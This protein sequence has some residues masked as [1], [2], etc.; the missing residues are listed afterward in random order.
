[1]SHTVLTPKNNIAAKERNRIPT[2]NYWQKRIGQNLIMKLTIFLKKELCSYF[3]FGVLKSNE[4]KRTRGKDSV[5]PLFGLSLRNERKE[6]GIITN[7]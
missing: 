5:F 7:L 1:M 4:N 6:F 3:L 2:P